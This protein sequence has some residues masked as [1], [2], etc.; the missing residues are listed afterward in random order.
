MGRTHAV[1]SSSHLCGSGCSAASVDWKA[2]G[3]SVR[4]PCKSREL[5]HVECMS[6]ELAEDPGF[7]IETIRGSRMRHFVNQSYFHLLLLSRN[8]S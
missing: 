6:E 2:C 7:Q 4:I 8:R 1:N 5:V 3:L